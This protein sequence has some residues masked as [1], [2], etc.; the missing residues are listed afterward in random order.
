MNDI[1][2]FGVYLKKAREEMGLTLSQLGELTGYSNPYLSQIETG[3][4]KKAPTPEL[5][6]KLAEALGNVTYAD[7]LAVAGYE[8]LA[9][10]ENLRIIFDEYGDQ[11]ELTALYERTKELEQAL[12]I[13]N[14]LELKESFIKTEDLKPYYNGHILT[15]QDRQRI[16]DVL[17]ALFPEYQ[18]KGND[19]SN[20]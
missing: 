8:E 6:K 3:K 19:M 15:E 1:R 7:L 2:K 9:K 5:L 10:N 20:T 13:K 11:K 14:F 4:R 18:E 16:L 17:K 12:D